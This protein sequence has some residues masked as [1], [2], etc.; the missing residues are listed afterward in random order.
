MTGDVHRGAAAIASGSLF[1]IGV[2]L[3]SVPVLTRLYAPDQ[4]GVYAFI[5]SIAAILAVAS[6]L[7]CEMAIT[8]APTDAEAG[9]ALKAA[10]LSITV[11]SL[12]VAA[13]LALTGAAIDDANRLALMPWL[14]MAPLLAA[15]IALTSVCTQLATRTRDYSAIARRTALQTVGV[16]GLQIAASTVTRSPGGLLIGDTVGRLASLVGFYPQ[17]RQ[18]WIAAG[19]LRPS[20]AVGRLRTFAIH[21][22]PAALL[23]STATQLPL[24]LVGICYGPASAG[25]LALAYRVAGVPA[26]VLGNTISQVVI[27]ELSARLRD[28]RADN[29]DLYLKVTRRLALVAPFVLIGMVVLPPLIFGPL[30][31]DDWAQAAS[32]V[33]IIAPAAAAGLIVSPLE[34]LFMVYREGPQ[35][36]QQDAARVV[37]LLLGGLSAVLAGLPVLWCLAILS[38]L[39]IFIYS[40]VW[41]RGLRLVSHAR[42]PE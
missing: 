8:S 24:L 4:Y 7:R 39:Q 23:N 35:K 33:Q 38:G 10:V 22:T 9:E 6:S 40:V 36:L 20:S 1:A 34:P 19:P 27:G 42:A 25:L 18:L 12:A 32:Y 29:R 37:L 28:G 2:S 26:T 16:N 41:L 13:V 30:F 11:V 5:V 31:G 17:A 3:L 21:F 14:L 15:A